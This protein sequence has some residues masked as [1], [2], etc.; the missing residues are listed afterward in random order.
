MVFHYVQTI[1]YKMIKDLPMWP[2]A[3]TQ[4]SKVEM[5]SILFLVFHNAQ[6]KQTVKDTK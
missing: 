5:D 4:T 1:K 6:A 3:S 2:T